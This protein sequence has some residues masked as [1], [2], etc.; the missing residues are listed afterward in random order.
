[1]SENDRS[2]LPLVAAGTALVGA[3]YGLGRYAYGVYLPVLRGEF[4]LGAS[5]AGALAAVAYAAYCIGLLAAAPVADRAP[6]TARGVAVAAGACAAA[7]TGTI[8]VAESVAALGS[9][10][11]LG[12]IGCGL[13]SPGL[14]ALVAARVAG[15]ERD[16]AMTVVN[17]GTG[18]GVLVCG[19]AALVATDRWRAS[20]ALFAAVSGAVTIAVAA[21]SG[22]GPAPRAMARRAAPHPGGRARGR[23]GDR[24]PLVLGALGLGAAGCAYST[25]GRDV[26]AAAGAGGEGP[27]VW[28]VLGAAS[29]GAAFTGD[30]MARRRASH[31]WAG[32][33]AGL[34]ASTATLALAP[35]SPGLALASAAVFG[36]SFVALTGVLTVWATRLDAGRPA[37]A[38]SGAF[39]LL[40]LGG[41]AGSLAVGAL[42]DGAGFVPA[43]LAAAGVA[44]ACAP[45]GYTPAAR[46]ALACAASSSASS[47][48]ASGASRPSAVAISQSANHAFFG[49]SGPCR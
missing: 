19:P 12:G 27:A 8:A 37:A 39:V 2:S 6:A 48:G 14:A 17:A 36:A 9:G 40:S 25:F 49:S 16:R 23:P 45:L 3:T 47:S 11:A 28:T 41:V 5:T 29:V 44:I 24:V 26:L 33:L 20:F 13:A 46:R 1:V 30:L 42:V 18:F 4:G 7:G 32:L 15:A 21:T 43:F 35:R 10:V 22:G 38:V 34:A 31:L